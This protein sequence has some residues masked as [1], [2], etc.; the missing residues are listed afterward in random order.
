M[1]RISKANTKTAQLA[2]IPELSQYLSGGRLIGSISLPPGKSC[3]NARTCRA[4]VE[5][6]DGKSRIVDGKYQTTRCFDASQSV[7]YK[8]KR[9][10]EEHNFAE[11]QSAKTFDKM[12]DLL[13]YSIPYHYGIFRFHVGGDFF[14]TDYMRAA[15]AIATDRK[16]SL[17]YA[18]TKE[19]SKYLKFRNAIPENFIFTMSYGGNEDHLIGENNLRYSVIVGSEKQALEMG[20]ESDH[21]DSH[22]ALPSKRNQ[23]FALVVHGVQPPTAIYKTRKGK[24]IE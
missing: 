19:V 1:L 5:T 22:A 17:F 15:I 9:L 10:N 3:P 11:L 20:L 23:S 12:Y 24:A 6:V 2:M 16:D 18:Y 7:I 14:S 8:S 21:D 13:D 4:H